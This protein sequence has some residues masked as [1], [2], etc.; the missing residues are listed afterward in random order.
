[1][2]NKTGWVCPICNA[3]M[4]PIMMYCINCKVNK[5]NSFTSNN[6]GFHETLSM[7]SH[8]IPT[9]FNSCKECNNNEDN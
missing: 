1:M 2:F 7:C 9:K 8:G 5:I 6:T 3:V 4:A